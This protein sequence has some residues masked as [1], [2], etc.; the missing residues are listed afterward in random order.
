MNSHFKLINTDAWPEQIE[1]ILLQ[2]IIVFKSCVVLLV[3]QK[4]IL[5]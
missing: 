5:V 4:L 3:D 2:A 1:S